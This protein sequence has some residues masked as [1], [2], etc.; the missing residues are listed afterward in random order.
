MA[1]SDASIEFFVTNITPI[2]SIPLN[3]ATPGKIRQ[4]TADGMGAGKTRHEADAALAMTQS[5]NTAAAK[6]RDTVPRD[7]VPRDN[8]P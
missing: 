1:S 3:S 4:I 2:P 6:N 7:T 5:R 8:F